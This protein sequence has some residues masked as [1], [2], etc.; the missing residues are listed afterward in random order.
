MKEQLRETSIPELAKELA[1][2][3]SQYVQGEIDNIVD[4]SLEHATQNENGAIDLKSIS[5]L[6]QYVPS[7]SHEIK[8][9]YINFYTTKALLPWSQEYIPDLIKK[10]DSIKDMVRKKCMQKEDVAKIKEELHRKYQP[11]YGLTI[12][13]GGYSKEQLSSISKMFPKLKELA[14]KTFGRIQWDGAYGSVKFKLGYGLLRKAHYRT[15]KI[16]WESNYPNYFN[17]M[18]NY[19]EMR[20]IIHRRH[21]SV[22]MMPVDKTNVFGAVKE[23]GLRKMKGLDEK[24]QLCT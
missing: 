17:L 3:T 13:R 7:V 21:D 18:K 23:K 5:D 8:R 9:V 4:K 24:K 6:L 12:K 22:E 16:D 2:I 10:L 15:N 14:S 1:E 11:A 20:K 19:T